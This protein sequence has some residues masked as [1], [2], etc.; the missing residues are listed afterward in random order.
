MEDADG[1][2]V[3]GGERCIYMNISFHPWSDGIGV[4][5]YSMCRFVHMKYT[6]FCANS[7][8][9]VNCKMYIE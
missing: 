4:L 3:E 9:V 2:E 6:R 7:H 8:Q 1:A 5:K